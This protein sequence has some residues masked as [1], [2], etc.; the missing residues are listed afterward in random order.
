MPHLV[1]EESH[2]HGCIAVVISQL[3]VD[4]FWMLKKSFLVINSEGTSQG[5]TWLVGRCL[6]CE[7]DLLSL[8]P[9]YSLLVYFPWL[10]LRRLG[11][12]WAF[13]TLAQVELRVLD[14]YIDAGHEL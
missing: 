13:H 3:P 10:F 12:S 1:R 6:S 2:E 4:A 5:R 8:P 7:P 9:L 14:G 11:S